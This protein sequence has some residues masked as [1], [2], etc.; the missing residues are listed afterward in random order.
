MSYSIACA[1]CCW[2]VE[3]PDNP[4]NPIWKT[5]LDETKEAGYNGLELGPYGYLPL[6]ADMIE[7]ELYGRAL[8]VCAGTIFE[9]LSVTEKQ[10]VILQK[11]ETLCR[12]LKAIKADK[13]VVI[14]CV[15]E[16]RSHYAGRSEQAPRLNEECWNV[17]MDTI[18]QIC[19]IAEKY[20]V[21]PVLHPHAG[22][23]IEYKDELDKALAQLSHEDIGLCLDTGHLYYAG[24]N[25]EQSLM[26]YAKRLEYVH[27]KDINQ[28]VL[29]QVIN[30]QVGFW[31]ACSQGIMCPIGEGAVDYDKVQQAL[32]D[33]DYQGWITIEQE[34]DPRNSDTTLRDIMR[35]RQFLKLKGFG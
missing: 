23:Y 26:H 28:Q 14:D 25:P 29:T 19:T 11:T 4:H 16:I 27:F 7:T 33:I 30:N 24:M 5:V 10:A 8:T 34:R 13:L 12:L 22:G 1:P 9:P 17:M 3:S 20:E 21:R 18:K 6:D 35:S 32:L 2:G 15:N 31:Q